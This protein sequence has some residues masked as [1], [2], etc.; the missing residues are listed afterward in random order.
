MLN[1]KNLIQMIIMVLIF[2]INLR[3]NVAH[4]QKKVNVMRKTNLKIQQMKKWLVLDSFVEE[5]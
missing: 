5:D 3:F 4:F 2:L 1:I